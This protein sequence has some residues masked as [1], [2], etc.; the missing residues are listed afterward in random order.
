S[1]PNCVTASG[2]SV[3]ARSRTSPAMP[4]AAPISAT[5]T[6]AAASGRTRAGRRLATSARGRGALARRT[7]RGRRALLRLLLRLRPLRIVA[8]LA[9]ADAG[10]VEEA[11]HPVGRR[12]ALG[13]P[14]LRL[15][16]V[17]LEPMLLRIL[18]RQR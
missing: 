5:H 9:L 3:K 11:Q 13:E 4:C 7:G 14:R 1:A 17:E 15:L 16:E 18:W 6:R 12:R 10:L 2:S 8:R